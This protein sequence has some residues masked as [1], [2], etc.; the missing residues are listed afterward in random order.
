MV[1]KSHSPEQII[2][3]LREAEILLNQGI[4]VGE[5]SRKIGVTEQTYYRWRKEY[6]GSNSCGEDCY[7]TH[8]LHSR[9][10]KLL[11]KVCQNYVVSSRG[12]LLT[13]WTNTKFHIFDLAIFNKLTHF[14]ISLK[15]LKTLYPF[16]GVAENLK[17]VPEFFS[18]FPGPAGVLGAADMALGVGHQ[19]KDPARRI[20]D[21]GNIIHRAV[22]VMGVAGLTVAIFIRIAQDDV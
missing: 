1:K 5:A 20:T 15:S 4:T 22:R 10:Y 8:S 21:G 11:R 19:S 9:E 7:P 2:N 18:A 17:A 16:D 3:K 14:I 12:G 13:I 6:G